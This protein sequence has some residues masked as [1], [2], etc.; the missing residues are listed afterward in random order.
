MKL[1]RFAHPPDRRDSA[2]MNSWSRRSETPVHHSLRA[3]RG[4]MMRTKK[5]TTL[6][7]NG[8]VE[9]GEVPSSSTAGNTSPDPAAIGI[10]STWE[11]WL[12]NRD[13]EAWRVIALL[14][15]EGCPRVT[16]VSLLMTVHWSAGAS[17]VTRKQMQHAIGVLDSCVGV[18][19]ELAKSDLG[20]ILRLVRPND[21]E[22][23]RDTLGREL[24][25]LKQ[26]L[27]KLQPAPS[28]GKKPRPP[29]RQQNRLIARLLQ[30]VKFKSGMA[31]RRS[32]PP[33]RRHPGLGHTRPCE[34]A[35]GK[36]SRRGF[37]QAAKQVQ[38]REQLATAHAAE[39][40]AAAAAAAATEWAVEQ[41]PDW[42]FEES[43]D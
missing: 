19:D 32:Q 41:L 29:H 28:K 21:E 7:A 12:R 42:P 16:L 2:I 9:H 30:Y 24:I 40:E 6:D 39:R 5:N 20:M 35:E 43:E 23:I 11:T 36:T 15:D 1:Q 38:L 10:K 3:L 18:L 33:C 13:P 14:E 34:L 31:G 4:Q 22:G 17:R 25:A 27:V 37:R 8:P 26:Q